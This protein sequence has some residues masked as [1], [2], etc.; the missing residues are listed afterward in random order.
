M[1]KKRERNEEL[2]LAVLAGMNFKEAGKFFAIQASYARTVFCREARRRAGEAGVEIG[3]GAT[4]EE[5]REVFRGME[6]GEGTPG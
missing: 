3:V 2:F 4:V 6:R 5:V 1:R